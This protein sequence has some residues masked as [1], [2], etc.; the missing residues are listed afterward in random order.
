[1]IRTMAIDAIYGRHKE[2][3][4]KRL[5]PKIYNKNFKFYSTDIYATFDFMS[6]DENMILELKS[7]RCKSNTYPTTI[8]GLNKVLKGKQLQRDNDKVV[9]F[10]FNF[11]DGLY[12]WD[13]Q[14]Y[15]IQPGGRTDLAGNKG[16]KDYAHINIR[17]LKLLQS[18]S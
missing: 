7:R 14:E 16:W 2:M 5:L 6:E 10:L 15:T 18:Y 4:V 3:E 11:T 1:M 13:N 17:D 12:E 8:V 9:K